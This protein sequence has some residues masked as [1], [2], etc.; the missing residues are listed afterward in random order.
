MIN[1]L[2]LSEMVSDGLTTLSVNTTS[3]I[4]KVNTK[5]LG[6]ASILLITLMLQ[7]CVVAAVGA[8]IGAVK[9]AN[10]KKLEAQTKCKDS[11]NTYLCLMLKNHMKPMSMCEYC[12]SNGLS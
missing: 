8:G 10:S 6:L 12:S 2:P 11:Y 9:W 3:I 1:K 7:G 5:L 4:M